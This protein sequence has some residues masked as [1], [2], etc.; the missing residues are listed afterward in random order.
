VIDIP[1]Q[2]NV[3]NAPFHSE[4]QIT[5]AQLP[6]G[7]SPVENIP[8]PP[9]MEDLSGVIKY[10]ET[11]LKEHKP[12]DSETDKTVD[13]NRHGE[14][15][16]MFAALIMAAD[17]KL[18]AL[19]TLMDQ[20]RQREYMDDEPQDPELKRLYYEAK[21]LLDLT[22][23]YIELY[24]EIE[25]AIEENNQRETLLN[26]EAQSLETEISAISRYPKGLNVIERAKWAK[27]GHFTQEKRI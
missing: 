25:S 5:P 17:E 24:Q 18:K 23:Q 20:E 14:G 11:L 15:K 1:N 8:Y 4:G 10:V 19:N 27:R 7:E 2:E 6:E 3:E 26:Q 16:E 21:K 12:T 9:K 22:Q 13:Q